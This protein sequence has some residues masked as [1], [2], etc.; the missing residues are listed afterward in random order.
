[1]SY[2][3]PDRGVGLV[4]WGEGLPEE[5]LEHPG[6]DAGD[7]LG[8]RHPGVSHLKLRY[9]DPGHAPSAAAAEDSQTPAVSASPGTRG[10]WTRKCAGKTKTKHLQ[11]G[12]SVQ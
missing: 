11:N 1:M 6:R 5:Q 8:Y 10:L 3:C 12:G 2:F 9:Q 7:D 4:F